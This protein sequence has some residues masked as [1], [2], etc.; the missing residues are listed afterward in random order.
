MPDGQS[1]LTKPPRGAS[2]IDFPI[3]AM[4][5]SAGG[6]DAYT[7]LI[8]S[9]PAQTGMAFILI[10]HL[11]PHH[12]SMMV[13]LLAGHTMMSV[14]QAI[15]GVTI[16]PDHLYI[17]PPGS[18]LSVAAG[19][20]RLSK[21]N[22]RHGTRLPFDFLLHSLAEYC[23]ARTIGVILSGTGSDGSLGLKALHDSGGLTIAQDPGE[24]EYGGMP[25]TAIAAGA[26]DLIL[27]IDQIAA[28]LVDPK[29]R[30]SP[31]K[32]TSVADTAS[33][34]AIID[35]LRTSTSHDFTLYKMG[36]LQRRI[37]RRMGLAAVGEMATYLDTLRDDP[38]ELELLAKDL[39]INV[40]SFFRDTPVFDTLA[41]KI[42][43]GM[44][45]DQPAG[46]PLRIWIAGCSTG[47]EAY[48]LAMLFR[49]AIMQMLSQQQGTVF[50]PKQLRRTLAKTGWPAS[51]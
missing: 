24:A 7:K 16:A 19:H 3:V 2:P 50:T 9:L 37:Q 35:L 36:T 13:D 32:K 27:P 51:L 48:S 14:T 43:P 5:A 42:V 6:L 4:G 21:P 34:P 25:S 29:S 46:L 18:Y 11:D 23:P 22:A 39:L 8:S 45:R 15:D 10:Q 28:A 12:E 44:V 17:I 1:K 26:V 31:T 49:E 47:E 41:T 40:T 20:L 38:A 33:L 30:T